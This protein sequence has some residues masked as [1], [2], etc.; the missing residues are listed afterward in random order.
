MEDAHW[1]EDWPGS[2]YTRG[3]HK[4]KLHREMIPRFEE[5]EG[6]PFDQ[7]SAGIPNMATKT[8]A[9]KFGDLVTLHKARRICYDIAKAQEAQ[10]Q[11]WRYVTHTGKAT[12]TL[13]VRREKFFE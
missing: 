10:A 5:F 7:P 3:R 12:C 6:M 1:S 4:G 2:S 9:L 8:L 11:G 13:Y